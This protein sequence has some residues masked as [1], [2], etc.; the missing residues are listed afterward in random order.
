VST[1]A[2]R[3]D[4]NAKA[5][6]DRAQPN[7]HH[8]EHEEHEDLNKAVGLAFLRA[9]RVLRD[10]KVF[11]KL[12]DFEIL[13]CKD[14]DANPNAFGADNT[15]LRHQ[16]ANA[17]QPDNFAAFLCSAIPKNCTLLAK[18]FLRALRTAIRQKRSYPTRFGRGIR[19]RGAGEAFAI[20]LFPCLSFP[21]Q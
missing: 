15:N 14:A 17:S 12:R 6:R 18:I 20:A 9:L 5:Q 21:C 10:G 16:K 4:F 8:E 1:P 2:R 7:A 3:E 13:Q 11:S 19:G